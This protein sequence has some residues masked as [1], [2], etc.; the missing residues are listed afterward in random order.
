MEHQPVVHEVAADRH[1]VEGVQPEQAPNRGTAGP[2][3]SPA[4]GRPDQAGDRKTCGLPADTPSGTASRSR[5]CRPTLPVGVRQ[6]LAVVRR[7]QHQHRVRRP[8]ARN[9]ASRPRAQA[10]PR[11]ARTAQRTG[12]ASVSGRAVSLVARAPSSAAKMAVAAAPQGEKPATQADRASRR[13]GLHR[14]PRSRRGRPAGSASGARAG[15]SCRQAAGGGS[16]TTP[17]DRDD[18]AECEPTPA[19]GPGRIDAERRSRR[20]TGQA[21]WCSPGPAP[22][23]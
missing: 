6:E 21:G 20:R 10:P 13:R 11:P 15:P 3:G 16:R 2:G 19:T 23:L 14:C 18:L 4:A 22:G 1:D 17:G 8:P 9:R 12:T 7:L 5:P